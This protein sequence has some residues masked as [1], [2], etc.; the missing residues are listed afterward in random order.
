MPF[1][2]KINIKK[3]PKPTGLP[4][5]FEFDL[6]TQDIQVGDQ[7]I[8]SNNDTVAALSDAESIR[9]FVFMSNQIAPNSTSSAFRARQAGTDQVQVLAS[10]REGEIS[11]PR[12]VSGETK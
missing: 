8:W 12:H 9:S 1:T 11:E 10:Q 4:A 7:I 6:P 3:N 5:I 2:W